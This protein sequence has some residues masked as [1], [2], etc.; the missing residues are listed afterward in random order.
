MAV[1]AVQNIRRETS[2]SSSPTT[3][4][5]TSAEGPVTSLRPVAREDVNV[6]VAG[7]SAQLQIITTAAVKRMR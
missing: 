6:R 4:A 2:V 7:T 1:A 5:V 3:S